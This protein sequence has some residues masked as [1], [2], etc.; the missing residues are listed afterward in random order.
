MTAMLDRVTEPPEARP[1]HRRPPGVDS[2]LRWGRS[3]AIGGL[4]VVD[5][6]W[7]LFVLAMLAAMLLIPDQE[8]IPYHL[9][10]VSFTL[11]YGYRMWQP[12]TTVAVLGA[13]TLIT[14][15]LFVR[16]YLK[17]DITWDE[18]AEIPLMT[19]IVGGGAWHAYRSAMAQR[20]VQEL[21]ALESSRLDRQR[22]FLRDTAH[23]IRTPVTI[24]RGNIEL[25]QLDSTDPQLQ[26]DSEEVLHQLDR[27][28]HMAR[29]LLVIEAL[30][31]SDLYDAQQVD[32]GAMVADAARRWSGAA[33]RSWVHSPRISADAMVDRLRLEESIDAMVEN[34]IRFTQTGGTIR[35]ACEAT[36]SAITIEVADDGPGILVEDRERVFERFFHR[37]PAGEEPGTG[38]GLA[39]VAAVA[40]TFKGSVWVDDAPEGGALVRLRLPR[41]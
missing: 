27:L 17:A 34:A 7:C 5:A 4:G 36:P 33:P 16:V 29:R 25:I 10:F 12:Q 18:L 11:L 6:L 38:L 8:T 9:I 24:A 32:V 35:I 2:L 21:A 3:P 31:T 14:G 15:V 19:L 23:A 39:L 22:A 30:H 37:H 28:H 41:V 40:A 26:Q 13:I 1:S 20:R